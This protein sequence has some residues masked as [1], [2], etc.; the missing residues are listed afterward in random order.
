MSGDTLTARRAAMATCAEAHPGELAAVLARIGAAIAAETLRPPETGLVMLRG[1]IGGDGR[2]FNLG[3]A[4]VTRAAL[5]LPDGTIGHAWHL[6]RDKTRAQHA[7]LLDGLWQAPATRDAVEAALAP[8]RDRIAADRAARA[9]Q[10]AATRV[11]FFTLV[12]GED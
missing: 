4:T 12:R 3:E 11:E 8:I 2:P 7:A 9:R 6:G 10:I 5:R 1:R